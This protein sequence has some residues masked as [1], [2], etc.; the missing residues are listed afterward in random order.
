MEDI[1][2]IGEALFWV[3]VGVLSLAVLGLLLAPGAA[4]TCSLLARSR[5]FEGRYAAAGARASSLLVLP[6]LYLLGHLLFGRSPFPRAVIMA[7]Y[8]FLYAVWLTLIAMYVLSL[9]STSQTSDSQIP[10]RV[11][12]GWCGRDYADSQIPA[13]VSFGWCGLT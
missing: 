5:G 1:E 12:F 7:T 10:A 2:N 3:P 6:F 9:F 4:L 8:V 11:S 13:R